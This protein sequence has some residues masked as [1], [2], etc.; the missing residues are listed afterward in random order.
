MVSLA[1][2]Q[3]TCVS[4]YNLC[5]PITAVQSLFLRC[6]SLDHWFTVHSTPETKTKLLKTIYKSQF[7]MYV[8][9]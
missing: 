7:C 1:D 8:C 9:I 2:V 4:L 3:T 6:V 5:V